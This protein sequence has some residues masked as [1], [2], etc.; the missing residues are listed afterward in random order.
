MMGDEGAEL[1]DAPEA[2]RVRLAEEHDELLAGGEEDGQRREVGVDVGLVDA[3]L[4]KPDARRLEL[5]AEIERARPLVQC[6]VLGRTVV[7]PAARGEAETSG[8]VRGGHEMVMG[9]P[10]EGRGRS[11]EAAGGHGRSP[12]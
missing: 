3:R 4:V 6:G 12:V 7:A 11:W 5:G 2:R 8:R 10:W 1:D 9:G